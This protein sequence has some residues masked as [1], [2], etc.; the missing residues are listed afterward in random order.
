MDQL[1]ST[2]AVLGSRPEVQVADSVRAMVARTE[3]GR[4]EAL[5]AQLPH[6]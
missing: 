3:G 2:V 4:A 6:L 5:T 1:R